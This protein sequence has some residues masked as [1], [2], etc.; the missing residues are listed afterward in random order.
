M[1][2]AGLLMLAGYER[3][4]WEY[5]MDVDKEERWLRAKEM[6]ENGVSEEQIL[7]LG[8]LS[9]EN[10]DELKR[11]Y[12]TVTAGKEC[13]EFALTMPGNED[14]CKMR[15]SYIGGEYGD[16]SSWLG[17]YRYVPF[18]E[19]TSFEFWRGNYATGVRGIIDPFDPDNPYGPKS[20]ADWGNSSPAGKKSSVDMKKVSFISMNQTAATLNDNDLSKI[21]N[22]SQIDMTIAEHD[23]ED[24]ESNH[25]CL[26][27]K[28]AAGPMGSILLS[29]SVNENH[30]EIPTC[31]NGKLFDDAVACLKEFTKGA[32]LG[33]ISSLKCHVNTW[34]LSSNNWFA[35]EM[36]TNMT[37]LTKFDL[38]DTVNYRHRSDLCMGIKSILMAAVTKDIQYIDLS[39]NFLDMDGG[40]AFASFLG[41]NKSLEVL[42][43]NRCSLGLKATEQIIDALTKNHNL[44]LTEF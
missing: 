30:L 1:D 36:V 38:S 29:K 12:G 17:V 22:V 20:S 15:P 10:E 8:L 19:V 40:R 14:G 4:C 33:K 31:P 24:V 44:N 18:R 34:G 16:S 13:Y 7:G 27:Q 3:E 25:G 6:R 39:D 42:K 43:V 11:G 32:D 21:S 23:L 9:D 41:E 28:A 37:C 26:Y 5:C 2:P 35:D